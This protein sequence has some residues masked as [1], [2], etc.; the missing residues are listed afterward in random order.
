MATGFAGML[1]S[2][3]LMKFSTDVLLVAPAAMGVI[4]GVGRIW[5]AISD[6]LAG[7]LSD[8][9][10]AAR[11]RRRAWMFASALPLA[12]AFVMVWSPAP[13][14]S[15]V[16]LVLWIGLALLCYET[17]ST[18]FGIPHGALGAELTQSHHDRTRLVGYRHVAGA[19]GG[20]L[21]LGGMYL[22]RTA[23]S[24]RA[25]GF[26]LSAA[27]GAVLVAAILYATARLQERADYRG[28]GGG[29]LVSAFRDVYANEHARVLL[30]V[31]GIEAF[32][33]ASLT[34]LAPYLI[35]YVMEAPNL[36]EAF[37]LI[38]FVP[39]FALTPLWIVLSRRV[40]K[41]K[42]W[43]M[44]M[45]ASSAG[46]YAIFF[47]EAGAYGILFAAGLLL[48]VGGGAAQVVA[49][50]IQADVIDYDELRTRERKEGAYVAV[51]NLIRKGAGGIA[52]MLTGFA[53]QAVGFVPNVEQTE[54]AKLGMLALSGL[55]PG[56]CYLLGLI[57]F[58]RFGLDE[59]EHTKILRALSQRDAAA[60]R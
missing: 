20:G 29:G 28:R 59:A 47:F 37:I 2:I 35:E 39:Q 16:G 33:V 8:R 48:G 24:P 50:S 58:S 21:S 60:R 43:L 57:V 27:V 5:D 10:L 56:S 18:V 17:A 44:S 7:H 38:Y 41:K 6:P 1:M 23:E 15:G 52:A 30:F 32:G 14:V 26:F 31:Y 25:M 42:L 45:V 53:L 46:F 12:L 4:Y 22:L 40:G 3:Y 49:P 54:T 13:G 51:W 36:T 55:L 9:S 11:G 34:V 19:V